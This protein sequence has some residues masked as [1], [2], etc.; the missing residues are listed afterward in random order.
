M[1]R[2]LGLCAATLERCSNPGRCRP[3]LGLLEQCCYRG[4]RSEGSS[5]SS[6]LDPPLCNETPQDLQARHDME[7]AWYGAQ[8]GTLPPTHWPSAAG[9]YLSTQEG[10]KA[11]LEE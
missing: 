2:G 4:P 8:E 7:L 6:G 10:Q 9:P 5:K 1:A 11:R 3:G